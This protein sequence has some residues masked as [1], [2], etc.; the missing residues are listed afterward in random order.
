M[1]LA[2][3]YKSTHI[4]ALLLYTHYID[5]LLESV[6]DPLTYIIEQRKY[7]SVHNKKPQ[8]NL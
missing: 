6:P 3:T 4:L 1:S 8:Q 5:T 7:G 2:D